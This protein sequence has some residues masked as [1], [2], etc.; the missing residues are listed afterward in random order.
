ML[1]FINVNVKTG[2]KKMFEKILK[3]IH[4]F[5]KKLEKII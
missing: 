3:S 2:K 4:I 5:I 1:V